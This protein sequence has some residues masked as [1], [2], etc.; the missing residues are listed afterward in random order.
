M[1]PKDE[2]KSKI[3]ATVVDAEAGKLS[4]TERTTITKTDTKIIDNGDGTT[5]KETTWKTEIINATTVINEKGEILSNT[6]IKTERRGKE[7]QQYD[8][9]GQAVGEGFGE[10]KAISTSKIEG[11]YIGG[12]TE[13]VAVYASAQFEKKNNWFNNDAVQDLMSGITAPAIAPANPGLQSRSGW[14]GVPFNPQG[15]KRSDSMRMYRN[16][17]S[18]PKLDS[19]DRFFKKIYKKKNG[20]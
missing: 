5:T 6:A 4:I 3:I 10:E 13:A 15:Y 12:K 17:Y 7:T 18:G 14:G 9:S 11:G 2:V 8:S 16:N 1:A 20:T 19:N